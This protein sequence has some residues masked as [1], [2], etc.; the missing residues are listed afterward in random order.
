MRYWIIYSIIFTLLTYLSVTEAKEIRYLRRSPKA[1]LM[2]DAYT[3][4][5][6][7]EFTLFYNPAALGRHNGLTVSLLNPKIS[8]TNILKETDRFSN[9]PSSDPVALSNRMLGFPVNFSLGAI[10]TIKLHH[11]GLNYIANLS[12]DLE[13][14]NA[15]HPSFKIDYRYDRGVVVGY[16]YVFGSNVSEGFRMGRKRKPKKESGGSRYAIGIGIK[17]LKR[18]GIDQSFDLFDTAILDKINEAGS[19]FNTL[20]KSLGY[21]KGSG[22]G[23]DIGFEAAY[24]L[25]I[26][27]FVMGT[28]LLDIANTRFK[29]SDGIKDIPKQ[30]MIW[31]YGMAW[32]QDFWIVD[33]TISMDIH[34]INSP[35]HFARKLHFGAE[36]GFPFVSIL[37]GW[38]GGYGSYGIELDVFVLKLYAGFYG[39][40]MGNQFQQK[41]SER[42]MIY[43]SL[44]DFNFEP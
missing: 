31:K 15:I 40:E 16:A 23:Y 8:G 12:T 6:D 39:I 29:N 1:L 11:F 44:L 34:P 27:K 18:E 7:D 14:R 37:V 33:Y 19:D 20:K 36:I 30:K 22:F 5:A 43:L 10:P 35:I 13:L 24:N 3:A 38:N 28:S 21:S 17:S 26:S 42:T 2:G 4:I 9:F 32:K 25:G 41:K